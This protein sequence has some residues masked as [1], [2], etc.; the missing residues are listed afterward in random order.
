MPKVVKLPENVKTLG[1]AVRYLREENGLTLRALATKVGVS[2][3]FLSDLEHDRRSASEE[4]LEAFAKALGTTKKDLQRYMFTRELKDW[5]T[6]R[7]EMLDVLRQIRASGVSAV[8]LRSA[9]TRRK[10][11]G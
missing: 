11:G 3:P 4:T 8:E 5:L 2:A 1:Q 6:E 7:P 9:I 10:S